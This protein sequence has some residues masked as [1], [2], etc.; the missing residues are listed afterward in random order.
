LYTL[1][2]CYSDVFVPKFSL[3][4]NISPDFSAYLGIFR[5]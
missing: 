5:I 2:V 4:K 1:Y 3:A